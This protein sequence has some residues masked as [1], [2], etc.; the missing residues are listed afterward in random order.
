MATSYLP[1][2]IFS[3]NLAKWYKQPWGH[4]SF[5]FD[6]GSIFSGNSGKGFFSF[7]LI[8]KIFLESSSNEKVFF[9]GHLG[10]ITHATR[11]LCLPSATRRRRCIKFKGVA[12]FEL[13]RSHDC[14]NEACMKCGKAHFTRPW[15][16]FPTGFLT[17]P[18][19]PSLLNHLV[20]SAGSN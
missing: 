9:T 16:A 2:T 5:E 12:P 20:D 17:R 15:H 18:V 1:P 14:P 19:L 13:G 8:P 10:L 4:E 11:R 6:P 3:A 7:S